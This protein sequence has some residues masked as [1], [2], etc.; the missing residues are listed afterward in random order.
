MTTRRSLIVTTLTLLL[1]MFAII[2]GWGV[3]R[4]RSLESSGR[5]F[6]ISVTPQILSANPDAAP[7]NEEEEAAESNAA[8]RLEGEAAW[9]HYA[10]SSLL[11]VQPFQTRSKYLF[12]VSRNLGA[13]EMIS[14]IS[15]SS[16]IPLPFIDRSPITAQYNLAVDFTGGTAEVELSLLYEQGRWWIT[17][18]NVVSNII[19]D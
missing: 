18:F 13:L 7:L 15:G 19:A 1:L 5:E 10:H 11:Q 2:L 8:P 14:S 3:I 17:Y 16:E 12:V 9:E 4:Q 6:A